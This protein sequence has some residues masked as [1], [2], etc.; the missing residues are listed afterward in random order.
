MSI[1]QTA[2]FE[3]AGAIFSHFMTSWCPN[4]KA[5]DLFADVLHHKT[6]Q[7]R[8]DSPGLYHLGEMCYNARV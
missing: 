3:I 4:G 7:N 2:A 6:I 1:P 5:F 8:A